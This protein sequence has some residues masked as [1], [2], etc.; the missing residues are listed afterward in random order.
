MFIKPDHG[1][2]YNVFGMIFMKVY[3]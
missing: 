3:I 1:K 2:L